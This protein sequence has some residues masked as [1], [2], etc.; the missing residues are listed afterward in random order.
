[1]DGWLEGGGGGEGGKEKEGERV[2]GVNGC[3]ATGKV[4]KNLGREGEN[5]KIFVGMGG[6]WEWEERVVV[7]RWTRW[8]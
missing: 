5:F 2:G 8:W 4:H 6:R 1:M 7:G 3:W